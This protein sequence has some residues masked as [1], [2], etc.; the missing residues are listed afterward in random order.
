MSFPY[1][2]RTY[3]K[4]IQLQNA[5]NTA[6]ETLAVFIQF[7]YLKL[8][9][10]FLS[11]SLDAKL[12]DRAETGSAHAERNPTVFFRNVEALLL[13]VRQLLHQLLAVRVGNHVAHEAGLAGNFTNAAHN[14][15]RC[16]ITDAILEKKQRSVKVKLSILQCLWQI[17][18]G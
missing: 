14:K 15:L 12:V 5:Q 16:F 18:L 6:K 4:I 13:E 3:A 10:E 1:L 7:R 9:T 11:N 2:R 8:D 17:K